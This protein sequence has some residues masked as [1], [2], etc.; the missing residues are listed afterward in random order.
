MCLSGYLYIRPFVHLS[1]C[2]SIYLSFYRSVYIWLSTQTIHRILQRGLQM[3]LLQK[4]CHLSRKGRLPR[5]SRGTHPSSAEQAKKRM[6]RLPSPGD[7]H[8]GPHPNPDDGREQSNRPELSIAL[9][10]EDNENEVDHLSPMPNQLELGEKESQ[11]N[12]RVI[13]QSRKGSGR[14]VVRPKSSARRETCCSNSD[15]PRQQPLQLLLLLSWPAWLSIVAIL[16]P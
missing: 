15:G 3:F 1:I 6:R 7:T 10:Q 12:Q 8:P 14:N 11:G 16:M 9:G 4:T 5:G 13:R 2:P